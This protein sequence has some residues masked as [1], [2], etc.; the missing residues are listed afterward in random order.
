MIEKAGS[1]GGLQDGDYNDHY[2]VVCVCFVIA[3]PVSR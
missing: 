3:P 1:E 2:K